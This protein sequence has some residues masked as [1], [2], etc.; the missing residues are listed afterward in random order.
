MVL[1]GKL[2]TSLENPRKLT[3]FYRLKLTPTRQSNVTPCGH[4]K[5]T[6]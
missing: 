1:I 6:P 3:P 4:C 5:L 2:N